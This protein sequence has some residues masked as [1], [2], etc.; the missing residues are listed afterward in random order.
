MV[1]G[2]GRADGT[3]GD[4]PGVWEPSRSPGWHEATARI[5]STVTS[6]LVTATSRAPRIGRSPPGSG[7]LRSWLVYAGAAEPPLEP[8]YL[9]TSICM[10]PVLLTLFTRTVVPVF[11]M[12]TLYQPG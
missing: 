7:G 10:K 9:L 5:K 1:V 11:G 12:F 4:D 2:S 6:S 3:G 8:V